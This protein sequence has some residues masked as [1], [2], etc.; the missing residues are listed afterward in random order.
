M[1]TD[2]D[3][4]SVALLTDDLFAK[5]CNACTAWITAGDSFI[6]IRFRQTYIHI[7]LKCGGDTAK[8][9]Q[10]ALKRIQRGVSNAR[11]NRPQGKV[12]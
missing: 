2:K 8:Q 5:S 7:C 9:L 1:A 4:P 6:Q 3:K 10:E 12:G 11:R